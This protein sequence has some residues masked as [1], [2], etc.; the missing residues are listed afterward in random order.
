MDILQSNQRDIPEQK[1]QKEKDQTGKDEQSD[2]DPLLGSNFQ[3]SLLK[4]ADCGMQNAELYLFPISKYELA[5]NFISD[6]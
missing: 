2:K 3:K 4:N 6:L 5:I 1:D